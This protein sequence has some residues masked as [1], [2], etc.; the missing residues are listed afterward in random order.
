LE[1]F[2]GMKPHLLTQAFLVATVVVGLA[3]SNFVRVTNT[4]LTPELAAGG[5]V[6]WADYD[7]DGLLDLVHANFDGPSRLFRNNGDGTFTRVTNSVTVPGPESYGVSWG[8][9]DNDG[10]PDLFIANG[11]GTGRA[12]QLFANR[13]LTIGTF[14]LLTT[15][16]G[17]I[18]SQARSSSCAWAD[19]DR[20]G[21]LDL[22]VSNSGSASELWHNKD[23]GSFDRVLT[24][25]VVHKIADS[26]GAAWADYDNDGWPDL[27]FVTN[28][29]GHNFLYHNNHDGTF[30]TV[31]LGDIVHDTGRFIS[32]AWSDYDNDGWI[33]L[34]VGKRIPG[35]GNLLYHNNGNGTFT[36]VTK[37]P[38]V[39][40]RFLNGGCAWGDYDRE[41]FLDLF[42]SGVNHPALNA[43]QNMLYHNGGTTNFWIEMA[44]GSARMSGSL[45][46]RRTASNRSFQNAAGPC[47]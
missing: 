22:F 6:A 40:D 28:A 27:F 19:Y 25:P 37:G 8:D 17:A 34:F 45:V 5:G 41:G 16:P 32:A 20:D 33:D 10:R 13:T 31:T 9:F 7:G 4:V 1:W 47:S 30:S 35:Q 46:R 18:N 43:G 29:E 3:Q 36:K 11:Y 44:Q 2:T 38:I 39:E 15:G 12:N 24:G 26:I 21:F 14:A 23:D 42:V